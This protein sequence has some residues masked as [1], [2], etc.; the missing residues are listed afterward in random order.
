[1]T[2]P[3]I[4]QA[5]QRI[6]AVGSQLCENQVYVFDDYDPEAGDATAVCQRLGIAYTDDLFLE[7]PAEQTFDPMPVEQIEAEEKQI[8]VTLPDDYKTLLATF[9]K[10]HLPGQASFCL[11]APVDAAQESEQF[12]VPDNGILVISS[13][14]DQSDSTMIGFVRDGDHFA[15][16]LYLFDMGL[17]WMD[18]PDYP[19]QTQ[20]A[21][22]LA[23]FVIRYLDGL[24]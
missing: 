21:D 9:G 18:D 8:G 22:S 13:F 7:Y 11:K 24:A 3:L 12:S 17:R 19:W 10:F 15:P 4:D 20:T 5:I 23:E 16:Q 6:R 14:T 1:M 2:T